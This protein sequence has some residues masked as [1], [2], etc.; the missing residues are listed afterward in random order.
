L[1]NKESLKENESLKEQEQNK[2]II[3]L[4]PLVDY[5]SV[6]TLQKSKNINKQVVCHNVAFPFTFKN[7][8]NAK[9]EL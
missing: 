7:N 9:E 2:V 8:L 4:I 1:T 5:I 6:V 3:W